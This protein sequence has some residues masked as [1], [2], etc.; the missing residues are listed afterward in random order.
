MIYQREYFML[1]SA[2]DSD[3]S[4]LTVSVVFSKYPPSKRMVSSPSCAQQM[5]PF[6]MSR[7]DKSVLVNFPP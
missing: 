7:R 3:P 2:E 4:V 1:K 6:L 5:C